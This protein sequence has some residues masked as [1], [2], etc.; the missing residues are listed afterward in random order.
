MFANK[1]TV[2]PDTDAVAAMRNR[3]AELRTSGRPVTIDISDYDPS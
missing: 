3:V 2:L 1:L